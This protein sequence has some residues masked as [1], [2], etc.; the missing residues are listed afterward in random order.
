MGAVNEKHN[1][2]LG[3]NR[4]RVRA[5]THQCGQLYY[6]LARDPTQIGFYHPGVGTMEAVGALTSG[7]QMTKLLGLAFG[8]GL[9][10]DVRDAY[11]YLMK[12]FDE[13]D[14]VF[15]FGF[16]RGA[17]TVRAVA[18][19]LHMYG[20]ISTGNEPLVPYTIRMMLAVQNENPGRVFLHANSGRPSR[21][22]PA[23]RI[24]WAY[25]IP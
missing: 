18:A 6:A 20:L 9:E 2:M 1:I 17:Y 5:R 19:L 23:V 10:A 24:L 14:R 13:G 7:G 25:G 4:E 22:G 15:L 16:S 12:H 11:V 3:W 21:L 8:Y